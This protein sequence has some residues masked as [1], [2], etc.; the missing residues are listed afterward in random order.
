MKT[1]SPADIVRVW[2]LG[3]EK[4]VWYRGLLMLAPVFPELHFHDL[5]AWPLGRR[6]IALFKL[7]A[8]LFGPSL[9]CVS[10]CPKCGHPSEFSAGLHQLCPHEIPA[11][12]PLLED[13]HLLEAE[14]V[15]V[16][17]R[18]LTS[19]DLAAFK[20]AAPTIQQ[21]RLLERAVLG[22]EDAGNRS[23]LELPP[24]IHSALADRLYELD[25]QL[26]LQIGIQCSHCQHEW[27]SPFD[28]V[29]YL[30]TEM[31]GLAQRQMHDVHLLARA[32]GWREADILAMSASRREFYVGKIEA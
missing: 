5:T 24:E 12:P 6:N 15:L 16:R 31:T 9:T 2:E 28:I 11:E 18:L 29:S 3:R 8:A 25:P 4:P 30:W 26:E 22:I 21:P 23:W 1:P 27:N 14:N 19:G 7:R 32:Y 10:T 17:F 20:D 13:E